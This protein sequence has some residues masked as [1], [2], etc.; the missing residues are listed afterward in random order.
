MKIL[1]HH[2]LG[3][4][5]ILTQ[6]QLE[7]YRAAFT[8]RHP[9]PPNVWCT[10]DGLKLSGCL[11]SSHDHDPSVI[12][13]GQEYNLR[14]IWVSSGC[15]HVHQCPKHLFQGIC[16][17]VLVTPFLCM[18]LSDNLSL[19]TGDRFQ[20]PDEFDQETNFC[21]SVGCTTISCHGGGTGTGRWAKW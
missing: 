4:L 20:L 2:E 9:A 11:R 15:P 19:L 1:C 3:K 12:L 6:Q 13:L 8:A 17:A 16:S 14:N 21:I 5:A 7:E 10:M 18:P